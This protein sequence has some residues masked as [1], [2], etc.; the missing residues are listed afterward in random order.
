[1]GTAQPDFCPYRGTELSPLDPPIRYHCDSC[2]H[3]VIHNPVLTTRLAILDGDAILL[4][5]VDVTDRDPWGTPG[6]KVEANEDP[7]VAGAR[8]LREETTLEV[9]PDD[10]VIF[11][12]R[13]F[14]KFGRTLETSD[15]VECPAVGGTPREADE[16][17]GVRFWTPSELAAA[18]DR[19]LPNWLTAHKDPQSWVDNARAVLDRLRGIRPYSGTASRVSRRSFDAFRTGT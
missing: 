6:G 3:L 14:A 10:L 8:E 1:M 11:D 13:T 17:V 16:V 18:G 19:L 4:V 12:A 9:D 5:K 15:A 2:D 7:A